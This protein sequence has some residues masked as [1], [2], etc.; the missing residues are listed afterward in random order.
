VPLS[1]YGQPSGKYSVEDDSYPVSRFTILRSQPIIGAFSST[2]KKTLGTALYTG[3]QKA[4]ELLK[5]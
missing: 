3:F 2:Y 5:S 1:V 4:A